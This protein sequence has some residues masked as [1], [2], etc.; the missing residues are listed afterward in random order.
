MQFPL[1]YEDVMSFQLEPNNNTIERLRNSIL[2]S[3]KRVKASK[4]E[5]TNNVVTF[6]GGL[7]RAVPNW[8][9]LSAISTGKIAI[10]RGDGIINLRYRLKFTELIVSSTIAVFVLFSPVIWQISS[11]NSGTK[12]AILLFIWYFFVGG[13]YYITKSRFPYLL[14]KMADIDLG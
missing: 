2:K 11:I 8:N 7:L 12:V 9:I 13:N 10:E 3:L 5:S 1:Y 6:S 14:K 4:I